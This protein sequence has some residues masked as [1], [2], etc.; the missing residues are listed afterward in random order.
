MVA[1]MAVSVSAFSFYFSVQSWRGSNRPFITVRV[2]SFGLGGNIATPLSLLVENTGTRPAKNVRLKVEDKKLED[3]MLPSR[4]TED[5]EAIKLCFS[6]RGVIP[7]LA[8]GNAVSNNF[9][10]LKGPSEGTW[11]PNAR[12][13]ITVS[14]E[15]L[16]GRRFTHS[17]PLLLADDRGF[18]GSFWNSAHTRS[19]KQNI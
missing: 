15:D 6:E 4:T 7:V 9:G 2:T 18:A 3:I 16:D 12:I 1:L 13:E 14:F 19:D 10:L 11:T 17:N 5:F 8:N